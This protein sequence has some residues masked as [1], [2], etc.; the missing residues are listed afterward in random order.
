MQFNE[1]EGESWS[2]SFWSA[3][4]LRLQSFAGVVSLVN[5]NL[6]EA[7]M[8]EDTLIRAYCIAYWRKNENQLILCD[9]P[10]SCIQKEIDD[11][12]RLQCKI[13]ETLGYTPEA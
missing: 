11:L 1:S 9:F 3:I 5:F 12:E 6:R 4:Q 10:S 8:S 13:V 2:V 7:S